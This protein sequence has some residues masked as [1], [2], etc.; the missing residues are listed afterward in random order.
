MS[1]VDNKII[2]DSE[3]N[4][5]FGSPLDKAARSCLYMDN[6]SGTVGNAF[7]DSTSC[8]ICDLTTLVNFKLDGLCENSIIDN[9]YYLY[10][11]NNDHVT[12]DIKWR[13][14]G[15]SMMKMNI[16]SRQWEIVDLMNPGVILGRTI[17]E[18]PDRENYP[19]GLHLWDILNDT[20]VGPNQKIVL[21][22]KFSHCSK[23]NMMII[24]LSINDFRTSL[25]VKMLAA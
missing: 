9:E 2:L 19:L 11:Y 8:H 21:N 18:S 7:C 12:W 3:I 25:L 24:K 5:N 23:V 16:A 22:L 10:H 6:P 20:C 4:W 13:G 1:I 15:G 17:L 14:F